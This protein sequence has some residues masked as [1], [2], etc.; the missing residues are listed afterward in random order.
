MTLRELIED[1]NVLVDA[2]W[3]D[4]VVVCDGQIGGVSGVET[5]ERHGVVEIVGGDIE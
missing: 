4:S 3:G 2:G 5:R 1:L